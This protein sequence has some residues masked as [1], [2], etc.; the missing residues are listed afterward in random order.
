MYVNI[1]KLSNLIL[2]LFFGYITVISMTGS[3][4]RYV[5]FENVFAEIFFATMA[6]LTFLVFLVKITSISA[7]S[8]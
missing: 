7:Q 3:I 6:S 2:T 8:K 5:Q 1:K 4:N